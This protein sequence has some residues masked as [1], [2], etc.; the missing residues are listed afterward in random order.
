VRPSWWSIGASVAV[1]AAAEPVW[2]ASPEPVRE[3]R[4]KPAA[5]RKVEL[6][7]DL[8]I[9]FRPADDPGPIRYSPGFAWGAHARIEFFPWLGLRPWVRHSSHAVSVERGGLATSEDSVLSQVSFDQPNVSLWIL[10]IQI[11]PTLRVTR[12]LGVWSGFGIDWGRLESAQ[13][14]A[15]LSPCASGESC[16][17][18][19]AYRTGVLV[20][21]TSSVGATLDLIPE[22]LVALAM[23]QYGFTIEESGGL[24]DPVQ[25]FVGG[26][27]HHLQGLPQMRSGVTVLL[28]V[29]LVR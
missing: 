18:Q 17:V 25:A 7:L 11:E 28:G 22:W 6:G 21:V 4:G 26:Q 19:T 8:G 3:T 24:F 9:A 20:E 14:S 12:A 2:A 27:M 5:E 29:G 1:L 10:G 23:L 16:A 13:P 15:V